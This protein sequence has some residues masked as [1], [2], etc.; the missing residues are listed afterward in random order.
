[1]TEES[2]SPENSGPENML[3]S[4]QKEFDK[5][6][7]D[8]VNVEYTNESDA[9]SPTQQSESE[10]EDEELDKEP[11]EEEES[12][13]EEEEDSAEEEDDDED[14][15]EE[16]DEDYLAPKSWSKDAKEAFYEL[17][18]HLQAEVIKRDREQNAYF[19]QKTQE[20][21]EIRERYSGYEAIE[22][23]FAER[24]DAIGRAPEEVIE[25]LLKWDIAFTKDPF[26]AWLELGEN[27]NLPVRE[28]LQGQP[29]APRNANIPVEIINEIQQL[30]NKLEGYEQAKEVELSSRVQN[31]LAA[32]ANEKDANGKLLRPYLSE[33]DDELSDALKALS[34]KPMSFRD[35]LDKAYKMALAANDDIRI[36]LEAAKKKDAVSNSKSKVEQA[37]SRKISLKADAETN[38][39]ETVDPSDMRALLQAN[40]KKLMKQR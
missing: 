35:R 16:E 2:Q 23:D 8:M 7:N 30:K 21:A 9:K 38:L 24:F 25:N 4:L 19:T 29:I 12:E 34:D 36:K 32:W 5:L 17:P 39:E 26:N 37:K 6:S 22:E 40:L 31:D 13:D 14:D 27:F 11:S 10:D 15:G 20:A 3:E 18:K 33:L 28:L 1:M